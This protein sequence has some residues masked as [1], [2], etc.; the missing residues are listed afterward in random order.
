MRQAFILTIHIATATIYNI[1]VLLCYPQTA[2]RCTT[3]SIY[4]HLSFFDQQQR[5]PGII[6]E[7]AKFVLL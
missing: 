1:I 6:R 2:W 7:C 4:I 3:K 5:V